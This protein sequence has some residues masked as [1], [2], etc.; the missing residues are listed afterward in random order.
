MATRKHRT[1]FATS[2]SIDFYTLDAS[3]R[4]GRIAQKVVG[5][6]VPLQNP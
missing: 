1:G 4:V 3:T 6:T 2:V 5:V